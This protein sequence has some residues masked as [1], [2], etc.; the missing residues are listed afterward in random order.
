MIGTMSYTV[1]YL[2][3]SCLVVVP[4]HIECIGYFDSGNN[5]MWLSLGYS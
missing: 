3:I 5:I 2:Y 1:I 4:S